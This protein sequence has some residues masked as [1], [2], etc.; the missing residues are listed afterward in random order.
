MSAGY[1]YHLTGWRRDGRRVN[2]RYKTLAPMERMSAQMNMVFCAILTPITYE[3]I[4]RGLASPEAGNGLPR[5]VLKA[6]PND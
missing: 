4:E 2:R 3:Q 5:I 1:K 6:K